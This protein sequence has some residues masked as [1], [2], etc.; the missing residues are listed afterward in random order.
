[1]VFLEL[2]YLGANGQILHALEDLE[3]M[4]DNLLQ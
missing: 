2:S 3:R 4:L 1:M